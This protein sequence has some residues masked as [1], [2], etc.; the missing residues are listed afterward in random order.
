MSSYYLNPVYIKEQSSFC[1][2]K[3]YVE[4]TKSHI[5]MSNYTYL[6]TYFVYVNLA[7]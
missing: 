2:H 7:H 5:Q 3:K 1:I 6:N 4:I